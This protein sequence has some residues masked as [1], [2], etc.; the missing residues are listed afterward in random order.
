MTIDFKNLRPR[1]YELL[2]KFPAYVSL[3][4]ANTDGELDNIEKRSAIEFAHVKT[5]SCDPL[6][7]DF[8]KEVDKSF[9]RTLQE[10]N[11]SLPLGKVNRDAIIKSKLL[12]I[13][14]IV[15]KLGPENMAI[16]HKSMKAFK[17]HISRAH[18]NILIDFLFPIPIP[19]LSDH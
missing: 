12:D 14:D 15:L 19:G 11:N 7:A 17:E 1:E 3:L 2:L 16:V 10:L 4:A 6:L 9:E 18:H 5:Y 13:E 8:F